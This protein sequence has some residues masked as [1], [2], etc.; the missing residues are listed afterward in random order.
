MASAGG[1]FDC[2]CKFLTLIKYFSAL[3]AYA[4]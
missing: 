1:K 4:E 2:T 3:N